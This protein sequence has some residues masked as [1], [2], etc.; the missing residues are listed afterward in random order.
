VEFKTS[1]AAAGG[2][3]ALGYTVTT[4]GGG[5]PPHL[6]RN[7]DE[8]FYI[9][10]GNFDFLVGDQVVPAP[11]GTLIFGP[12]NVTHQFR[13][14][15]PGKGGFVVW[16]QPAKF[17]K[18]ITEVGTP[19]AGVVDPPALTEKVMVKLMKLCH[20]YGIEMQPNAP[21][22]GTGSA[23]PTPD[24]HWVLGLQV[25]L[26]CTGEQSN[27]TLTVAEIS[28]PPGGGP[29]THLHF[30]QDEVFYVLEGEFEFLLGD[31]QV[32]G[33]GGDAIHVP[34]Q[35]WHHFKNVGDSTGRLLDYHTPAGMEHFFTECAEP[36]QQ[37]KLTPQQIVA[38]CEKHGMKVR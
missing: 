5:P 35:T 4:P 18:F 25:K 16:V 20:E 2:R 28:A 23:P 33:E 12:R 30:E 38:I 17:E 37:V 34:K 13:N 29:P 27:G 24:A 22:K 11:P 1:S 26:L 3:F 19:A 14:K 31:R 10:E 32:I 15:G 21:Q 8:V 7:E 9:I 36:T 6:H